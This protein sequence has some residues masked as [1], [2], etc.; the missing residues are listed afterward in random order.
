MTSQHRALATAVVHLAAATAPLAAVE[1]AASAGTLGAGAQDRFPLGDAL[2]FRLEGHAWTYQDERREA[3]HLTY[4]AEASWRN[5]AALLDW[6]P[7]G[8]AFR[9]TGGAVWNGNE[10]TGV[11]VPEADGTYLIGSTR[12]PAFDGTELQEVP[13][14]VAIE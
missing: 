5:A 2:A 6:H 13:T 7:G 4:D 10:I 14:T 8:R 12:V 3:G 9:L 1:I 11:S